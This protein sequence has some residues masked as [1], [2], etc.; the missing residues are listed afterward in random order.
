MK[1]KEFLPT[2]AKEA[3]RLGWEYVDVVLFTGDAYIDHPSFGA[4]V[5]GRSLEAAGYRVAIV[6]QP[7]W[8]G[9]LRDFK[10]MGKPRL[11]FGVTA[12]A[13]DSLV[14]KYTPTGR[15]RSS[16]AYTPEGLID[17]RPDYPTIVYTQILKKLFPDTPVV[18]GG[19]EASLRRLTHY[20]YIEKRLRPSFLV[21]SGAD[22]LIYGMGERSV[23]AVAQAIAEQKP[24]T[25]LPQVVYR[26]KTVPDGAK[27]LHPYEECVA[28]AE[29][30]G[31][32]F[33]EIETAS[34]MAE[35]VPVLVEQTAG[36]YV[37]VNPPYPTPT[38]AECDATYGLPYVRRPAPRYKGKR[39]AA[40]DMIRHSINT[41]RGC[42]GGCSFCAISMHQGKFIAS[43]S[44]QSIVNEA[45]II[46]SDPEFHGTVSDLGGPSANMWRSGG[47][48]SDQCKKC[49]RPS[50]LFPKICVNLS[51]SHSDL[52]RLLDK[53]DAVQGIKHLF[54][55]SGIRGDV[56]GS[57]PYMERVIVRHTGGR[58]KVAP[59]HTEEHVLKLMRKPPFGDFEALKRQF[60]A[61]CAKNG[62]KFQLIP[63]FIS[64]HPGCTEKDMQALKSKTSGVMTDQVQDFTPTP[65]TL[66]SVMFYTGT[67]PYTGEKLYV[68]KTKADKDRQKTYFFDYGRTD[69]RPKTQDPR[70]A[71]RS[72]R[73]TGRK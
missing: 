30:F 49:R 2:S 31:K 25:D 39:I 53:V 57:N 29:K 17:K 66:S 7:D 28:S 12:G 70:S 26:S 71:N 73:P 33:I 24:L 20:D 44:E 13:M 47:K 46:A 43:R 40:W 19:V 45:K 15:L 11:F 1:A 69:S 51:A 35:N 60:E 62:L 41:H 27:N 21:E 8:H 65:M 50:C 34:N 52:L 37:V 16:D 23:V 68:A 48:D 6:P 64:A 58:L 32:N 9:D 56:P 14:N 4:A 38:Q 18:V 61:V 42:Y 72:R 5:I 55:G 22:L 67:N 63:Y 36:A 10:K 59:E 54:V 3:A